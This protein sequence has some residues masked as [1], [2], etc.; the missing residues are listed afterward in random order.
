MA[1]SNKTRRG[2]VSRVWSPF[3]HLFRATSNSAQE[4]GATAGRI[5]KET[6]GLPGK[7]GSTF[8]RHGNMTLTNV[9]DLR[10]GR[11]G[12]SRKAGKRRAARK[13]RK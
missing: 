13:S 6:V 2:L 12:K 9:F 10:S 3:N 8:A 5:A 11:K 7:V 1:R 4:V